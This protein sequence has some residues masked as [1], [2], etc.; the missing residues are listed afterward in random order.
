M[1]LRGLWASWK[2]ALDNYVVI[3]CNITYSLIKP[4]HKCFLST[5]HVPSVVPD[6]KNTT[7]N[8]TD[9][10]PAFMEP[11][12]WWGWGISANGL[13][14]A[15]RIEVLLSIYH[16]LGMIWSAAHK[17]FHLILTVVLQGRNSDLQITEEETKVQKV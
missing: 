12:V 10:V 6:T 9:V 2:E 15:Y 4:F 13:S 7:V 16:V 5:Y 14:C 3:N 17:L 1:I 8:K 11:R